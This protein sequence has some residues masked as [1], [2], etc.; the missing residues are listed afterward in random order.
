VTARRTLF[1][2]LV[3]AIGSGFEDLQAQGTAATVRVNLPVTMAVTRLHTS[4]ATTDFGTVSVADMLGGTSEQAGP[5]LD[6]KSNRP[7][8]VTIAAATPTF[9]PAAKLGSDVGWAL[10]AGG[11]YTPLSTTGVTVLTLSSGGLVSQ[12]LHFRILWDLAGDGPGEYLLELL[13]TIASP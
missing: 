13:V 8:V 9:G 6:V 5:L 2:A 4:S 12:P 11:P 10:S 1:V 7:F 3:C